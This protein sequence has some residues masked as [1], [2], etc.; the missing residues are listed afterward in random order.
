M[1]FALT[2]AV[3]GLCQAAA[4]AQISVLRPSDVVFMYQAPREI[5]EDYGAT[6]LAWGGTPTPESLQQAA[7]IKYFGSVGMVTEFNRYYDRD[8][9]TYEA[10]LCRDL[11]GQPFKVPWLTDHQ[12]QG[13]PLLVVLHAAASLPRVP[14]GPRRRDGQSRGVRS[15]Y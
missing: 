14:P 1:R 11:E 10:G 3:L 7:G 15:A 5:Y 12:H 4:W 8:P 6:L 2:L 13:V 9:K